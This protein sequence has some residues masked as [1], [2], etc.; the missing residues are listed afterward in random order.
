MDGYRYLYKSI[1]SI[2]CQLPDAAGFR[3]IQV[4]A[5]AGDSIEGGCRT[6]VGHLTSAERCK[7]RVSSAA[8]A[9]YT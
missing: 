6:V 2:R 3:E 1:I 5:Q 9:I 7:D 4:K 8:Q